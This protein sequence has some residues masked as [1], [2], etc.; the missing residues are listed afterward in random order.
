MEDPDTTGPGATAGDADF[1]L[2]EKPEGPISAAIIAAGVG[3]AA[4]GLLTT[5]TAADEGVADALQWSDRVGP[6]AGKSSLAVVAWLLSWAVL[7]A[8]LRKKPYETVRALVV[9]LVLVA[10]GVLG[11]FPEFFQLFE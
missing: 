7:H 11:T 2:S 5:L 1:P 3:A 9:G 4:L 8:V 10:L 6:L